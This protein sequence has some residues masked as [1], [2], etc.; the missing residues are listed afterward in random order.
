[1]KFTKHFWSNENHFSVDQYFCPYQTSKNAKIIFHKLFY[2][3][4][5]GA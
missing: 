2:I 4:T 5:N 1:L 3:K